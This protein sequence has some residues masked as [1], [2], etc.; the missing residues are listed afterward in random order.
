MVTM[1]TLLK[2]DHDQILIFIQL[3]RMAVGPT[4]ALS[5]K[6]GWGDE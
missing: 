2:I 5:T 3:N 4:L 1:E 6:K